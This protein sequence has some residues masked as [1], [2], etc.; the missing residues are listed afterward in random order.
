MRDK[1]N[2]VISEE[3]VIRLSTKANSAFR[4]LLPFRK[5]PKFNTLLSSTQFKLSDERF[6]LF[7]KKLL[8]RRSIKAFPQTGFDFMAHFE[9][10]HHQRI[11]G[12]TLTIRVR[13]SRRIYLWGGTAD[14]NPLIVQSSDPAAVS[15]QEIAQPAGSVYRLFELHARR[16]A[17]SVTITAAPNNSAQPWDSVNF[18]VH[19]ADENF[20]YYRNRVMTIA[21]Q[22][23][24]AHYLEGAA[25][26][27]PG[28]QNGMPARPGW[29][30]I[31]TGAMIDRRDVQHSAAR[32]QNIAMVCAG[33]PVSYGQRAQYADD[34]ARVNLTLETATHS[35]RTVYKGI[36]RQTHAVRR[37]G[38]IL[39]ERCEGKRHFDCVG[40]VSYCLSIAFGERYQL[41]ISNAG[42]VYSGYANNF[43]VIPPSEPHLPGDILIFGGEEIQHRSRTVLRGAHH[44]GF[45]L[46]NGTQMIHAADTEYGVVISGIG[47]D[48]TRR[49]RHPRLG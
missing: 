17:D 3:I 20:E 2:R 21:R 6:L 27:A 49:V 30:N 9:S 36:N 29:V 4:R 26:A 1:R 42:E 48:L 14:G 5:H 46:G 28:E 38:V 32:Y 24:G 18:L 40:F 12:Q 44:I 15:V 13:R 37:L 31:F 33:K 34:S 19:T 35:F 16:D 43:R 47:R 10:D 11:S 8:V 25:G 7:C 41:E 39:G 45:S 22:N 23:L